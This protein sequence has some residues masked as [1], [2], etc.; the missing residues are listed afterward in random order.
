M[1]KRYETTAYFLLF[2]FVLLSTVS[3]QSSNHAIRGELFQLFRVSAS[4]NDRSALPD[5]SPTSTREV[6]ERPLVDKELFAP[7][8]VAGNP[9]APLGIDDRIYINTYDFSFDLEPAAPYRVAQIRFEMALISGS[10][11]KSVRIGLTD[12]SSK[13]YG[14][15][16]DSR[17]SL[18]VCTTSGLLVSAVDQI[19]V[20]VE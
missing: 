10:T 13:W 1:Q 6:E 12:S 5:D 18:W 19:R 15:R 14:C 7:D 11:P 2:T 17:D 8:P 3:A 9:G 4:T 16:I 20:I